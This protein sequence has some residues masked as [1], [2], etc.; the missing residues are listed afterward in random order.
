MTFDGSNKRDSLKKRTAN[1]HILIGGSGV[2]GLTNS[3]AMKPKN[4]VY[5]QILDRAFFDWY[6]A[7]VKDVDIGS[8]LDSCS[9]FYECDVVSTKPDTPYE[10]GYHLVRGEVKFLKVSHGGVNEGIFAKASGHNAPIF[11]EFLRSKYPNHSVSRADSA[12]DFDDPEAFNLLKTQ[13]EYIAGKYRI[14]YNTLGDWRSDGVRQGGRTIQ[15]GSRKS[16]VFIRIYEKGHEQL[17]K[18]NDTSASLNWVR[19]ELELKPGTKDSKIFLSH[20]PPR[21]IFSVNDWVKELTL[22]MGDH[23]IIPIKF[24]TAHKKSDLHRSYSHMV[25]QYGQT[26]EKIVND[27]LNGDWSLLSEYIQTSIKQSRSPSLLTS[28]A[29]EQ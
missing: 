25:K 7:T 4:P 28:G 20:M 1:P 2:H 29:N 18:L 26:I 16:P 15:L 9:K 24:G 3:P 11:S 14:K 17:E 21:E 22:T 8:F 10:M 13:A 19:V 6:Q 12:I 5:D 27:S 23:D